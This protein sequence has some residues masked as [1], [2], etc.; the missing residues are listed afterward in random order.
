MREGVLP[1]N[2]LVACFYIVIAAAT[3]FVLK[4]SSRPLQKMEKVTEK[5]REQKWKE[6]INYNKLL[7]VSWLK[8]YTLVGTFL[9]EDKKYLLKE[10]LFI[11]AY[12]VTCLQINHII[13]W[14]VTYTLFLLPILFTLFDLVCKKIQP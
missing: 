8:K 10:F 9:H 14:P 2:I 5:E 12:S 1:L 11:A 13:L 3:G 7:G 6:S 4:K